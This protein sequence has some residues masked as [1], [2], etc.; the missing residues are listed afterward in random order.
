M[1]PVEQGG[2]A[3]KR[4]ILNYTQGILPLW[5]HIDLGVVT[6]PERKRV[7]AFIAAV[8]SGE[9]VQAIAD[10]Y[11]EE[12][13]MQENLR[14]PRRGRIALME[15]E[16]NALKQLQRMYTHPNPAFL[17]DG[18]SVAI[19]WVFD[20]TGKDGTTRRLQEVTLQRW[21]GDR[22]LEERFFYDSASAWR[23]V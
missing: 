5:G 19:H 8:V 3:A 7:E 21:R 2:D 16:T 18:D 9:H 23:A 14:E 22:I 11:H 20:A 17:L 6:M 15:H 12:A 13:S 1:N 4:G 10:F